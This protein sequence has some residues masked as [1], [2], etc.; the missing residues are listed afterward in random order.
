MTEELIDRFFNKQCTPQESAEVV[1]F[2]ENNPHI[3]EKYSGRHEWEATED[4]NM[5]NEFWNDVWTRV[6][7]K[8]EKQA[9]YST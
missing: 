9:L 3:L 1:A 5:D 8:G 7:K 6:K 4:V 2:L